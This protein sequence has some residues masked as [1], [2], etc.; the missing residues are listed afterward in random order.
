M[1]QGGSGIQVSGSGT[2][3]DPYVIDATATSIT[4]TLVVTDTPTVD[5]T[6]GGSG[7]VSDPY[8]LSA[9]ATVSVADLQDVA[10]GAPATGDTLLWNGT[11]WVYGPPSSGGGGAVVVTTA[12]VTG[13]GSTANPVGVATSGTW[14]TA[15]LNVYGTNTLLGSPTYV[16]ANGQLRAQPR[17]ADVLAAGAARPNQYP[18]RMIV[19]DGVLYVSTG[20]TWVPLTPTVEGPLSVAYNR[21]AAIGIVL[22]DGITVNNAA[23]AYAEFHRFGPM[24][25][26]YM[27]GIRWTPRNGATTSDIT[28]T[29][30]FTLPAS[31]KGAWSL[32][33]GQVGSVGRLTN[34][35]LD[36]EGTLIQATAM[37]PTVTNTSS[38]QAWPQVE[39]RLSLSW[40]L[41]SSLDPEQAFAQVRSNALSLSEAAALYQQERLQTGI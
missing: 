41:D 5:L 27:N 16:D 28:N 7:S 15:P 34:F 8:D 33:G 25:T 18:G 35:F 24:I 31:M 13:D 30:L 39:N 40:Q 37:S 6:L 1:V 4:G 29:D 20:S 10:T 26:M 32:T 22:A 14:G 2:G 38:S 19:Q 17:G 21:W 9:Q 23:T 12:P 3:P 36:R 11:E